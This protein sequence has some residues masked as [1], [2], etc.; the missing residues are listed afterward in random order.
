MSTTQ[1]R[2]PHYDALTGTW[3][4]PGDRSSAR[5]P[6]SCATCYPGGWDPSGEEPRKPSFEPPD[7][8]DDADPC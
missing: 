5:H 3:S 6:I 8:S 2:I 1:D 7:C 4:W